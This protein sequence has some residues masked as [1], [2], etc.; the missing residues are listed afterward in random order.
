MRGSRG[1]SWGDVDVRDVAGLMRD[2][3]EIL[4]FTEPVAVLM[5]GLLGHV[6]DTDEARALVGQILARVPSGSYLVISDAVL[7]EE[8]RKTEES[9]AGTGGVHY[10]AREPA[11]IA[12]FFDGLEWVEPGFASV[13]LR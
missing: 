6:H 8:R 12:S 11:D 1:L 13:S 9:I 7:T 10:H 5:L 2:A 3:T 4:D